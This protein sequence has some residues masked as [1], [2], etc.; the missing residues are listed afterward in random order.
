MQP[1]VQIVEDDPIIAHDLKAVLLDRGFTVVGTSSSYEDALQLFNHHRPDIMLV[2]ISLKGEKTGIELAETINRGA[3]T[4]SF[5][6]LTGTSD[7]DTKNSAFATNPAVFLTKPFNEENV[8]VSLELAFN[9]TQTKLRNA[10]YI[11]D[12]LFL[13]SNGRFMKV[14]TLEISYI[15]GEGSYTRIFTDSE[16]IIQT[17]N[18]SSFKTR[19]EPQFIRIHRSYMVNVSRIQSFDSQYVYLDQTKLPIGRSYKDNVKKILR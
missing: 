12:F 11:S 2:D 10:N 1:K 7:Q 4:C 14:P 18:L 8:I 3:H 15:E 6:Y 9:K 13:K 5:V 16:E 19:L 17:G